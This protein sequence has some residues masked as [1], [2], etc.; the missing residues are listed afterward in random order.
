LFIE[1]YLILEQESIYLTSYKHIHAQLGFEISFVAVF[2]LQ[3][4]V[5]EGCPC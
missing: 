3:S 5:V 2:S 1:S 4:A